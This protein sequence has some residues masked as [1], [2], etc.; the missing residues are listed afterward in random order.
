MLTLFAATLCSMEELSYP[1]GRYDWKAPLNP[2]RQAACKEAI[3]ALPQ[4][5]SAALAGLSEAQLDEPY[6]PD[7]WTVRQLVHHIADSHQNAHIRMRLALTE[8]V[9]TVKP[10]EEAEWAKLADAATMSIAP[11]MQIIEAVHARWSVLLDSLTPEQMQ[12]RAIHPANGEYTLAR[13]L[14]VYD[15]HGRHHLAHIVNWRKRA[16]Y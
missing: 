15:W 16:G 4:Q 8:D 14:E 7:G 3:R 10:Y 9:P 1:I 13:Q 2:A 11:S 12:R 6:R 5:L